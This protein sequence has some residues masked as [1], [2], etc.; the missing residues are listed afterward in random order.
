ML[1]IFT[2]GWTWQALEHAASQNGGF[3]L[4]KPGAV[5]PDGQGAC[6]SGRKSGVQVMSAHTDHAQLFFNRHFGTQALVTVSGFPGLLHLFQHQRGA[7]LEPGKG[8]WNDHQRA[9]SRSGI[10]RL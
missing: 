1:L 2:L 8:L 10:Q 5:Y 7:A 9:S 3:V 6:A 4:S